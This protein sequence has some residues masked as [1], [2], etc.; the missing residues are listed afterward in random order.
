MKFAFVV[1]C[2]LDVYNA[3]AWTN[4]G[5]LASAIKKL[6]NLDVRVE[7][8]NLRDIDS[9][10]EKIL[11]TAPD[12]IGLPL[13]QY[14]LDA[15]LSY[16]KKIK[17]ILPNVKIVIGNV[18]ASTHAFE[19]MSDY[20]EI[21]YAVLG[22][23]EECLVEL[24]ERIMNNKNVSDCDGIIYREN[25]VISKTR[26]RTPIS[27]LD[28]F[29]FPD[30]SFYNNEFNFYPLIASRGCDGHCTF[31]DAN[32]IYK[33]TG[34]VKGTRYRSIGN[35]VDEIILLKKEYKAKKI[36]FTDSTF[37]D[38]NRLWEFYNALERTKIRILLELNLRCDL[39]SESAVKAIKNLAD[40]GLASVF[41][42]VEAFNDK[43]L[44]LYGKISNTE[45]NATALQRLKKL[46]D[47]EVPEIHLRIGFI[48]FNAYTTTDKLVQN[49]EFLGK[50]NVP[51]DFRI[52]TS[53]L[54]ITPSLPFSKK[55]R[56]DNLLKQ[57]LTYKLTD[58]HGYHFKNKNIQ[59]IYDLLIYTNQLL[60]PIIYDRMYY[61]YK[62]L[63]I[64][65]E[66]NSFDIEMR[67]WN[68]YNIMIGS[69]V[70]KYLFVILENIGNDEQKIQEII[71]KYSEKDIKII[72]ES[73][74]SL[75]KLGQKLAR[76]YFASAK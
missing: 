63:K 6:N 46:Y 44:K 17:Y 64:V 61:F 48:N 43:D 65:I 37:G 66:D 5:Y 13:L 51:V 56:R 40:I 57:D 42:G 49:I 29:A 52:V 74:T 62:Y 71:H 41:L 70:Y 50:H 31:C 36:F 26:A 1:F 34:C 10:L 73:E 54:Q 72:R 55:L 38:E 20:P 75:N 19:I 45:T 58:G 3:Y 76:Y 12:I 33:N 16:I 22:E 39:I 7:F 11:E 32:A 9:A 60:N 28:K 4:I 21:D 30:R 69:M 59:K 14:N 53:R 27:D 18:S 68:Q 15:S 35:I 24:C 47:L 8:Y 23:G 2:S 67:I 25:E